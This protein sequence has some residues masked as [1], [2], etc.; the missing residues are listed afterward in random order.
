MFYTV[1]YRKILSRLI[2]GF[3]LDRFI[4]GIAREGG[5]CIFEGLKGY[6]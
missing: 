3:G 5:T 4:N 6:K 1:S 2:R